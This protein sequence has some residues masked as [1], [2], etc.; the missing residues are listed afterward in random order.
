[1]T[2]FLFFFT[3]NEIDFDSFELDCVEIEVN[4]IWIKLNWIEN[5]SN[6]KFLF[7]TLLLFLFQIN[8]HDD[9]VHVVVVFLP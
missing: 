5:W 2:V 4:S 7:F 8:K 6:L 9:K 1:M 3:W